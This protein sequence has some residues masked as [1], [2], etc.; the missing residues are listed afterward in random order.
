M[1][2]IFQQSAESP[3]HLSVAALVT[4]EKKQILCHYFTAKDLPR[5]SEGKSDVYL[6]MRETLHPNESLEA[7]VARGLMEEFG[8]TGTITDYL[9]SI[10]SS[11]P[12]TFDRSI[13][14]E[15]TT[16]YFEVLLHS[17]DE[18]KREKGAVESRSRLVWFEPADLLEKTTAQ[19]KACGR[20][21]I[22]DSKIVRTFLHKYKL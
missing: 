4:N 7:G 17:L 8:A 11:F 22:D 16:L 14:I 15:K 18:A 2:N 9:G 12:Y 10:Q 6:L 20:T 19:A 1:N 21:D 3:F 13:S 5:E